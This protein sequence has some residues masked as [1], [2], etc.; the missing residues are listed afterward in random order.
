[1]AN[2]SSSYEDV[3]RNGAI[4]LH[5][6]LIFAVKVCDLSDS[7][8]ARLKNE[9]PRTF[10]RLGRHYRRYRCLGTKNQHNVS[11]ENATFLSR[12]FRPE[13]SG[14]Q[15]TIDTEFQRD[16][17]F[18]LILETTTS[19]TR[20]QYSEDIINIQCSALAHHHPHLCRSTTVQ[21]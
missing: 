9:R 8:S 7:C 15:N 1:M 6:L 10:W 18:L 11:A 2:K 12:L 13:L 4:Y 20:A 5:A 14:I 16:V 17:T 3:R 21:P 19:R